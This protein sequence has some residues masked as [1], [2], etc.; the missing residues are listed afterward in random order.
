MTGPLIVRFAARAPAEPRLRL[1]CLAHAG[2]GIAPFYRWSTL[3]PPEIDVLAVQLPAREKRLREEPFTRM[4][5]IVSA[6]AAELE[7]LLD[8]P[9]ALFGHSMGAM[10]AYELACALRRRG[11]PL[12]AHL[13]LS[14]RQAVTEPPRE[15]AIHALPEERFVE[16]VTRR[17][18]G[19]PQP[20]L[21]D[22]ELMSIFARALRA[23]FE[24]I[25]TYEHRDAEPLPIP[26]TIM[27]GRDDPQTHPD[28]IAGWF[29]LTALPA[30][31]ELFDG[32]HF[33]LGEQL[34]AV[35]AAIAR[36]L[37]VRT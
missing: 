28:R 23:D 8:R 2:G 7:P 30:D 9:V 3:L 19:I 33:Y 18:G 12:P 27:G 16:E 15:R 14:G 31:V 24:V 6:L 10:I 21:D 26:F 13:F 11:A 29:G 34:P 20:I 36:R 22:K 5:A 4:D 35:L 17:F 37:G 1:L 32:G 25:E